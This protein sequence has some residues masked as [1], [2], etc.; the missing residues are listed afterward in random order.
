MLVLIFLPLLAVAVGLVFVQA[1]ASSG[2]LMLVE[3]APQ[4]VNKERFEHVDSVLNLNPSNEA[5]DLSPEETFLKSME[6][7]A[8]SENLQLAES[9]WLYLATLFSIAFLVIVSLYLAA[10]LP[11]SKALPTNCDIIATILAALM[12]ALWLPFR[13]AFNEETKFKLFGDD[14]IISGLPLGKEEV[15]VIVLTAMLLLPIAYVIW[16]RLL[17]KKVKAHVV[18][19]AAGSSA[20]SIVAFVGAL[21]ALCKVITEHSSLSGPET[22]W[23][24]M[25]CTLLVVS[26]ISFLIA[27]TASE[28]EHQPR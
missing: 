18:K 3:F 26:G 11:F 19:V 6:L 25:F 5:V 1:D 27:L 17:N 22:H 13:F 21:V 12:V 20:V 14:T 10:S 4:E 23:Y 8:L 15:S 7:F 24:F 16:K 28:Q 9:R 2:K